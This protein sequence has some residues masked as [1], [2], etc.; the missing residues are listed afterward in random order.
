MNTLLGM[1]I[2]AEQWSYRLGSGPAGG[3]LSGPA[4]RPVA[5]RAVHDCRQAFPRGAPGPG[6]TSCCD[7]RG[8]RSIERARRGRADDG[9]RRRSRGRDRDAPRPEGADE[10]HRRAGP[11]GAGVI[12]SR[13]ARARRRRADDEADRR[14]PGDG[15]TETVH[16]RAP[17]AQDPEQH[18]PV[19][20]MRLPP[21]TPEQRPLESQPE[22]PS[23]ET[24]TAR[25]TSVRT[26]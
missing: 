12:A 8:R 16:E 1:A 9:G 23:R 11:G 13:R 2:D 5:L 7:R 20:R 24:T 26:R 19:A 4:I 15:A 18:V 22:D 14:D 25:T 21:P 3:G 6:G 10:S 17:E